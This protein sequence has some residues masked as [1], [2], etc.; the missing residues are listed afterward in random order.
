MAEDA[1][2]EDLRLAYGDKDT[3][4][5]ATGSKQP[6]RR[7][8][9]VASVVTAEEIAAM[10]AVDLDDVMETIPGVHVARSNNVY[11]PLYDIRGVHTTYNPETLML[12][13]G[14][15]VTTL[16]VGNRGNI[17]GGL[18]LENV[19][20]IEVIR[21]P[22]SALYGADA[23][24][25][26]INIVTKTADDI[27][28]TVAGIRGGSNNTWDGWGL[29]GGHAGP[30]AI[31]AYVGA[32]TT[33]GIPGTIRQDAQSLNDRLSGTHASLAPGS[34]NTGDRPLDANLDL[35]LEGWRLRLGEKFRDDVGTGAGSAAALDPVG[36]AQS[37]R[38]NADLSWSNPQIAENLGVGFV[39]SFLYYNQ[40]I[41]TP[42][43][44][45]PP[46]ATFAGQT[47]PNGMLGAPETWERQIR[48][49]TYATYSGFADHALR[50]GAGHDDLDLYKVIT[51]QNYSFSPSGGPIPAGPLTQ[52]NGTDG[53]IAPHR[54]TVTYG[55]AQDEWRVLPDWTLTAGLRYDHYSDFG[56]TANPRLA[57]VWDAALNVTA[58]LLYGR[59]FRAPAFVEEY[60]INNPVSRGNSNLQPETTNTYEFALSWQPRPDLQITP[61]VFHDEI[62]N[63]ILTVANSTP[64]T[65]STFQNYGGET[66]NG[67]ELE[68][69]WD[70]RSDLKLTGNY[71]FQTTI[72]DRTHRDA[73]YVPHNHL[74][75]RADWRFASGWLAGSE[76]NW[77]DTRQRGVGDSRAPLEGYTTLDLVLR[78]TGALEGWEFAGVVRNLFDAKCLEPSA[79]PPLSLP[80]DLPVNPR[81]FYLQASHQF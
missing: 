59:A 30:V 10:G 66:G 71:S 19:A 17:W 77:V 76:V 45:F 5:I 15:P 1:A 65:G 21:G 50:F 2:D 38:T 11:A 70:A 20:R 69:T 24:S 44:L 36:K 33:D 78:N 25:G 31:A 64:G 75:A 26:V 8:P 73:G 49:S 27:N 62:K 12:V 35:A 13:N 56:G 23:F 55:Y 72:D 74:N 67:F 46:G 39:G 28:G 53:F 54:R 43:V 51:Y 80:Y 6:L 32:G 81:T 48:L 63:L 52:V 22:G 58:K 42:L 57:L 68:A 34:I 41:P 37:E 47:F 9:A 29:Y 40:F 3:V 14:V 4:A 16:L 7:A 61:S 79:A 60:S 18:P